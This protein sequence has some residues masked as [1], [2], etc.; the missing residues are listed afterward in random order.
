MG[1]YLLQDSPSSHTNRG[2]ASNS[3]YHKVF[4]RLVSLLILIVFEG[5]VSCTNPNT[6]NLGQVECGRGR[7]WSSSAPATKRDAWP[8]S[9]PSSRTKNL[10]PHFRPRATSRGLVPR[11]L[12]V[13][14]QQ[15]SRRKRQ[16]APLSR[17]N[18][19][20]I[21]NHQNYYFSQF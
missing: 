2:T 20:I 15:H 17:K 8:V 19:S 4:T 14:Q 1:A 6:A 18:I 9:S 5:Y 13:V 3:I 10:R 12:L 11:Q 7:G 21:N 16:D